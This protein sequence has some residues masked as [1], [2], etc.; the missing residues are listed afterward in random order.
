MLLNSKYFVK[1]YIKFDYSLTFNQL[2][3]LINE[4]IFLQN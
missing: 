3:F 4:F 2:N 1:C